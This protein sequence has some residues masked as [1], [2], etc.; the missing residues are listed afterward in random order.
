MAIASG[1]ASPASGSSG[2]R[3]RAREAAA[4]FTPIEEGQ[5]GPGGVNPGVVSSIAPYG[6]AAE[7]WQARDASGPEV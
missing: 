1:S 6:T 5:G 2:P 7:R 3:V 4:L